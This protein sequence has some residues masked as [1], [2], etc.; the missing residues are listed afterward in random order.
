MDSLFDLNVLDDPEEFNS[1]RC[2]RW[3]IRSP[4]QLNHSFK[5]D[6]KDRHFIQAMGIFNRQDDLSGFPLLVIVLIPLRSD[7]LRTRSV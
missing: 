1:Q 5:I 3:T 7:K 2:V 6:L 4:D